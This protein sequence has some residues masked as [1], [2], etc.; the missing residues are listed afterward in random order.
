VEQKDNT[1][2]GGAG[3]TA[4]GG[5]GGSAN[6]GNIVE[7]NGNALA[8]ADGRP[9][10]PPADG[11]WTKSGPSCGCDGG[12]HGPAA[13][14]AT[15]GDT[16]VSSG[17]ATGGNG[18]DAWANGGDAASGIAVVK[19]QS[20]P[21]AGSSWCG[22]EG[23]RSGGGVEQKDNTAT[24]GAGGTATG[25][26]GGDANSGNWVAGNGNALALAGG[27]RKGP[28]PKCGCGA[29][30]DPVGGP[31]A[32]GGDT[33]VSSGNATGGNG[34]NASANGGDA[35]SGIA[36]VEQSGSS[37]PACGC[38]W[39]RGPHSDSGVEQ[40]DN[41]ATGG[42]GGTETGG[43]G[44]SANSGNY[45][46]DNGN[47]EAF[48]GGHKPEPCGCGRPYSAGVPADPAGPSA[49]GGDTWVTS[50]DATGGNGGNAYAN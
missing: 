15:G 49:Q 31:S 5:D 11:P 28:E 6:T 1:A 38:A 20:D 44:G 39:K 4:T 26:Y 2:T 30:H 23:S 42:A 12:P 34:G 10:G 24:G 46:A 19:Q 25:G 9:K 47:A 27:S 7:H 43:D 48:A 17:N 18:G 21:A 37:G 50:G 8:K 22:C 41:T 36:F 14:S 3:G 33:W 35:A 29:P 13:P 45:V 32:A 40:K 16:W